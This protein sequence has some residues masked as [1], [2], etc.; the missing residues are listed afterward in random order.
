MR[1][2]EIDALLRNGRAHRR[3]VI[4]GDCPE[5]ASHEVMVAALEPVRPLV[6]RGWPPEAAPPVLTAEGELAVLVSGM[7]RVEDPVV[8]DAALRDLFAGDGPDHLDIVDT[9]AGPWLRGCLWWEDGEDSRASHLAF[10]ATSQE[11]FQWMD[12]RLERLWPPVFRG[13]HG[14]AW[15]SDAEL[16]REPLLGRPAAWG[17]PP[18]RAALRRRIIATEREWCATPSPLLDGAVPAELGA[19]AAGLDRIAVMLAEAVRR[20]AAEVGGVA[21]FNP[22]RVGVARSPMR[23]HG[24]PRPRAEPASRT[25]MLIGMETEQ[26]A[27]RLPRGDL[28]ALDELVEGGVYPSRAAAVRAGVAAITALARRRAVDAAL[29]EGY[30]RTPPDPE[31]DAAALASLR[32]AIAEEPW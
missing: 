1:E 27:V 3:A 29:V 8:T 19:T 20:P 13:M 24:E 5:C 26:I 15:L 9:P 23:S 22:A 17:L 18:T 7:F 25:G 11:R 21:S 10:E 28:E 30:R 16:D 12:Y 14:S 32:E 31:E 2:A 6:D 4:D